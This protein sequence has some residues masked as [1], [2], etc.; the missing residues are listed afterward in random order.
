[1]ILSEQVVYFQL[2][3][4]DSVLKYRAFVRMCYCFCNCIIRYVLNAKI[5]FFFNWNRCIERDN[6]KRL[7]KCTII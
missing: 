7:N 6:F 4:F 1:M 2:V 3:H 5:V